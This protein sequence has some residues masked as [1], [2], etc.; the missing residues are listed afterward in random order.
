MLF[1]PSK[2]FRACLICGDVFQSFTDRLDSPTLNEINS[3]H[4]RREVWAKEH[5]LRHTS[6]E[7][8]MLKLSGLTMTPEAANKLAAF[9]LLPITDM[10]KFNDEISS[11]LFESNPVPKDDAES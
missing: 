2:T 9:G 10:A 5:A 7:H 11:A 1:D 3:A 8:L 4:G 6:K